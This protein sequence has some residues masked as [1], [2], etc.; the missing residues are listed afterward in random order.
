MLH[1]PLYKGLSIDAFLTEGAKNDRV[2]DYLPDERDISRLPRQFIVNVLFTIMGEPI[3]DFVKK[4]I[5]ARN[6]AVAEN[7]NLII[8]LDPEIAA[9]FA[10]SINISSKLTAS[11]TPMHLV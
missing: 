8:E 4:S 1:A 10:K 7:R 3:S 9:A 2:M 6:D 5:K 11:L